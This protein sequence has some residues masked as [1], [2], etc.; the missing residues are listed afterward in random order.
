MRNFRWAMLWIVWSSTVAFGLWSMLSYELTPAAAGDPPETWPG[1]SALTRSPEVPTLV[2]FLHPHC[3]C[4]RATLD[5]LAVL[6]ARRDVQMTFVFH[7]PAGLEEDWEQTDLWRTAAA[8]PG[9]RVVCDRSGVESGRF[10][11]RTSGEALLYD[12]EGRLLFHGGVTPG[13]GHR[14]DNLGRSS[15]ESLLTGK[16]PFQCKAP[17]FGCPLCGR[18]ADPT[19]TPRDVREI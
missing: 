4:S 3:P 7:K 11:T 19:P 15:L 12:V 8:F 2:V 16:G 9:S 17:V 6:A 13:R 10:G 5:E 18:E 1:G 14:G